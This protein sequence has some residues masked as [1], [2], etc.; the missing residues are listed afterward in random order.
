MI[1]GSYHA[2]GSPVERINRKA[3]GSYFEL[4]VCL[5]KHPRRYP[6]YEV[7]HGGLAFCNSR[8]A[9]EAIMK[10]FLASDEDWLPDIFC[11]YVY[12]RVLDVKYDRTEYLSCWLYNEQGEM[13]DQRTFPSY[14]DEKGFE[15]RSDDEVRFRFGDIAE[16]YDGDTVSLVHVLAPPR[17]KEFYIQKSIEFGKP[18]RG[19]ISDDTY[20]VLKDSPHYFGGHMHVD[21]LS[22]FQ[23]HFIIPKSV[24][25]RLDSI[26]A[27]Y[28][29]DRRE[30]YEDN[31]EDNQI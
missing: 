20:I 12:K 27:G 22:L 10:E 9:A 13:I 1:I 21:A 31:P 16:L 11:F 7:A 30:C 24:K 14:W 28:Q 17:R 26:W 2:D 18:Y 8:E 15:G 19:D 3:K 29:E 5:V 25:K 23:P 4:E 6:K